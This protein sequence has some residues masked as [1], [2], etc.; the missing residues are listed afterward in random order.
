[1]LN[2]LILVGRITHD[3]EPIILEDGKKVLR[4]QL[5]VQRAFKNYNGEYDTDFFQIT[6]WEGLATLVENYTKKGIMIAVKGR[7]QSWQYNLENGKKLNM[8]DVVA[9][10]ITYLSNSKSNLEKELM[11]IG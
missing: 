8:I 4:F 9:E 3:P 11:E 6:C 1:M 10:K 2:Q 7:I 5:A